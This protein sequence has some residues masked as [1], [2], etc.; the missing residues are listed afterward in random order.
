MAN[1]TGSSLRDSSLSLLLCESALSFALQHLSPS[2]SSPTQFIA[3]HFSSSH[4]KAFQERLRGYFT[5]VRWVKPESSRKESKEGFFVCGGLRESGEW[6]VNEEMGDCE[7][8]V[9]E[10]EGKEDDLYF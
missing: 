9:K 5:E 3:K 10:E 4:T 1:T 2:T 7:G 6:P 8:K